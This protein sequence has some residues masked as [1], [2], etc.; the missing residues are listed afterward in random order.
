MMRKLQASKKIS[1]IRALPGTKSGLKVGTAAF[2]GKAPVAPKKI[3]ITTLFAGPKP[4]PTTPPPPRI[5]EATLLKSW[6]AVTGTN[7]E[8]VSK[9]DAQKIA[10]RVLQDDNFLT[11]A[12]A[13]QDQSQ[14]GSQTWKSA[15][16]IFNAIEEYIQS[17]LAEA[18]SELN[19][20][21]ASSTV[22]FTERQ[23]DWIKFLFGGTVSPL[24][25][26]SRYVNSQAF[27]SDNEKN[28]KDNHDYV[29]IVFPNWSQSGSANPD[30][31]IEKNSKAWK[32]L[33]ASRDYQELK[34]NFRLVLQL[35]A[36][37]M[38]H[39]WGLLFTF[40]GNKVALVNNSGSILYVNGD[41]N[42]LR[43]TRFLIALRLF[44]CEGIFSLFRNLL[45][46]YFKE[47]SSYVQ[48]WSKTWAD[49]RTIYD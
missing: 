11:A 8:S 47:H 4:V 29:Q 7:I 12:A 49:S 17:C 20:F 13:V 43:V 46:K 41:H 42:R 37:R 9:W 24:G 27:R 33:F 15:G 18:E 22:K 36:I 16:H 25:I 40:E 32:A 39:F 2:P 26:E 28:L 14:N 35:N 38:L 48:H 30:L 19:R 21:Q 5:D 10:Q 3:S 6:G 31:C 44:K 1:T 45:E 34:N 23:P